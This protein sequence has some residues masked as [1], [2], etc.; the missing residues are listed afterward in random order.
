MEREGYILFLIFCVQPLNY[1]SV[2]TAVKLY[3]REIS[4]NR[5]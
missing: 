1:I 2:V 4:N 5:Q 3:K